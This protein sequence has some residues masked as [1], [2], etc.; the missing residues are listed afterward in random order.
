MNL[1]RNSKG[2]TAIEIVIS[3]VIISMIAAVLVALIN[4]SITG[5]CFGTSQE[6]A[7][8]AATIGLQKLSSEIRDGKTASVVNGQ[9]V[10]YFPVLRTDEGT[11]ESIYDVTSIDSTPRIYYTHNGDLVRSVGGTVST[12][13]RGVGSAE[14]VVSLNRVD[15]T[16]DASSQCGT[17]TSSQEAEG[18]VTLRNYSGS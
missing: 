6:T 10:V 9:L 11:G 15:I 12:V 16:L 8:N 5:Y 2:F 4:Q 14:F 1:L 7:T 18:Y 3:T 13:M 17:R